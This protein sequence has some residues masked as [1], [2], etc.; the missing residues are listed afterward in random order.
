[1]VRTSGECCQADSRYLNCK[2]RIWLKFPQNR[3]ISCQNTAPLLFHLHLCLVKWITKNI[4]DYTLN[5]IALTSQQDHWE[6]DYSLLLLCGECQDTVWRG[7]IFWPDLSAYCDP[8]EERVVSLNT[9][10][11]VELS[12]P[13]YPSHTQLCELSHVWYTE[14]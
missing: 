2:Q 14:H 9:G 10:Y 11:H 13:W 3:N 5:K 12:I 4:S 6:P 8:S 7:S 1:M